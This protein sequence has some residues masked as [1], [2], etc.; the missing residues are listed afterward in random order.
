MMLWIVGETQYQLLSTSEVLQLAQTKHFSKN[1][2][3]HPLLE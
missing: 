2:K 1:C 3:I